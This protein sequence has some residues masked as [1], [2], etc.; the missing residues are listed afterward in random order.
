MIV[1]SENQGRHETDGRVS[2]RPHLPVEPF[3]R[4]LQIK[5]KGVERVCACVCVHMCV[6]M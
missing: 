6:S 5:A 1:R 2:L 4:L 3:V